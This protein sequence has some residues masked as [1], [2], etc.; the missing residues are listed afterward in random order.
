MFKQNVETG[1]RSNEECPS[2]KACINNVCL[3][4]CGT[5]EL[6]P[7]RNQDCQVKDHQ[8]VCITGIFFVKY[9]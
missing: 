4:V 8:A 3:D 1:C 2:Q 5:P 6:N 7:C 9:F